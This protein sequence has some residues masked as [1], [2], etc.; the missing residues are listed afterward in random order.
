M[1]EPQSFLLFV[2]LVA[3]FVAMVYWLVRS[4]HLLLRILAG[5]CAFVAAAV[6]GMAG[7]NKYYDYYQ[8][9]GGLI[10]DF[11]GTT[12]GGVTQ[13]PTIGGHPQDLRELAAHTDLR[14]AK[15]GLLISTTLPGARSHIT[16]TG[17]VY[18]PPQ[19]FEPAYASYR[20]PVLELL[21]GSPGQPLDWET[22][23]HT[24]ETYLREITRDK[25][26]PAVLVM[27]DVNGSL[28][29]A[30]QCL[31]QWHGPQDETY[32]ARDVPADIIAGLRV[33]PLGAHW[34]IAGYS[35]GGYCAANLA[36]RHRRDF[37]VAG[38]M[39]GYFQPLREK[40]ADP[41]HGDP[42]ARLAN[43]PMWLVANL[44]PDARLPAF[45]VMAGKA[46][47]G[48]L[49]AA[50]AF[51]TELDRHEHV[52]LMLVSHGRHSF[53]AWLKALPK[54]LSW[55]ANRL[56]AGLPR[57]TETSPCG[58]HTPTRLPGAPVPAGPLP[59]ARNPV[60]TPRPRVA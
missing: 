21:H 16:R 55:A 5:T 11:A 22:A 35:E 46:D 58:P 2:L 60:G 32:L 54:L 20:F 34:G 27:P 53:A 25:V 23:L 8:T 29:A 49:A 10:A 51:A 17:L 24:T 33:Q 52:P 39:S 14:H 41:F 28:I 57:C 37:G 3:V 44:P 15:R 31:N 19:Y 13:L 9:W 56:S 12:P 50:I 30:E 38:V 6:F 42:K 59:T 48:D 45:W 47:R 40:G 36:L 26:R 1:L 4:T 7:V 18:L 43:D